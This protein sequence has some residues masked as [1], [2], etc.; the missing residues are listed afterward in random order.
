MTVKSA[1]TVKNRMQ[2]RAKRTR[3]KL[4]EAALDVF[5]EKSVDAATVEEITEKA[6]LGKGT[7]YQH[8]EDKEYTG[9][10]GKYA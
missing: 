6:D 8:F 10:L 2:K 5:S 9:K 3:K 4:K 7:L 1:K